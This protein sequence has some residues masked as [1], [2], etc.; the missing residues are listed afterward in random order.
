M[1][2]AMGGGEG[3]R[4]ASTVSR[5]AIRKELSASSLCLANDGVESQKEDAERSNAIF[6]YSQN[7]NL[8]LKMTCLRGFYPALSF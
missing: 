8:T 3:W 2:L 5:F 1:V 4:G 7:S 6:R